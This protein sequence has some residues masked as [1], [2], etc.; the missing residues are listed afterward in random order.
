MNDNPS[1]Y[2]TAIF[3]VV[4]SGFFT[5]V[6][7]YLTTKWQF[8]IAIAEKQY[9]YRINAY[10]S[11][12]SAISRNNSP[13]IAEILNIGELSKH[14]T[15]DA[16]IQALE[17]KFNELSKLNY[18]YKIL[19]QL[20]S[21]FSILRLHGSD[22]VRKYCDDILSVLALREYDV[23]WNNYPKE[24]VSLKN[25]WVKNQ[26]DGIAYGWE[27]KVTGEERVMFVILSAMY[28]NLLTQL[29]NELYGKSLN[30]VN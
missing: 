14:L 22:L 18:E 11:F 2:S 9:E 13:M 25:I 4:L 26:E 30:N 5:I 12:L 23:V 16:E 20:D 3:T 1:P 17:D 19:W 8:Q 10:N 7:F 6:G 28:K 24:L 21:D 29:R 27:E 15:T